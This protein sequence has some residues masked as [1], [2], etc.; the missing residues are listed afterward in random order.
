VDINVVAPVVFKENIVI[1]TSMS[2]PQASRVKMAPPVST[3]LV[4]FNVLAPL[5]SQENI[6]SKM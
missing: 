1:K 5:N 4:D 6:A 2:V 3:A